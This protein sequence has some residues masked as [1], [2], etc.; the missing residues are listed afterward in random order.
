MF[1]RLFLE[2]GARTRF[3]NY[4]LVGGL[5][6]VVHFVVLWFLR[7]RLNSDLAFSIA[8]SLSV[9]THYLLLRFWA[10]PSARRDTTQ[11]F[12]EYLLAIGVSYAINIA[13]FKV[14]HDVI[15]LSVMWAAFWAVPPS[16]L[17]IYLLLNF[18]VFRAAGR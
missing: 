2:R 4:L 11:Q 15:G 8:Y 10:L 5:S 6:A 1:R 12:G 7:D 17:I 13:A 16:T 9:V 3:I 18:R 14:A